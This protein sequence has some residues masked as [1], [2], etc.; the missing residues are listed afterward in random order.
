MSVLRRPLLF[1]PPRVDTEADHTLIEPREQFYRRLANIVLN[2]R[3][4]QL[5]DV[6]A[7][8]VQRRLAGSIGPS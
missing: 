3:H 4:R 8:L 6:L 1:R 7:E 2:M 5:S